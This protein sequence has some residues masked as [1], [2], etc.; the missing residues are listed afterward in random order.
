MKSYRQDRTGGP[1]PVIVVEVP[2]DTDTYT[3]LRAK[4][5]RCRALGVPVYIVTIAG[6]QAVERLDPDRFGS[7][8]WINKPIPELGGL[9][10]TFHNGEIA[11]V[12]PNDVIAT[13]DHDILAATKNQLAAAEQRATELEQRLQ[14]GRHRPQGL[15][16]SPLRSDEISL[17]LDD[18]PG[19]G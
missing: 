3:S 15:T 16:A 8:E 6:H 12:L 11:V 14:G 19:R 18:D 10:L 7:E 17:L 2:S 13:S 4:A 1:S 5:H 9:Q